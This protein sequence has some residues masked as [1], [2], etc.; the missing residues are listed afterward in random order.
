MNQGHFGKSV[1]GLL[2]SRNAATWSKSCGIISEAAAMKYNTGRPKLLEDL[3]EIF[4][5][6][7]FLFYSNITDFITPEKTRHH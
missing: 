7:G 6:D 1:S 4:A 3:Y 5:P 2:E